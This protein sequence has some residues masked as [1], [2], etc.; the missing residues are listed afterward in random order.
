MY[1]GVVDGT[2]KYAN[3]LSFGTNVDRWKRVL[4]ETALKLVRVKCGRV[5]REA[6]EYRAHLS[7]LLLTTGRRH[8]S[9]ALLL[10]LLPNGDLRKRG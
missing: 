10:R 8:I 3:T 4:F 7:A 9:R 5:P 2:T 1:T 6:E